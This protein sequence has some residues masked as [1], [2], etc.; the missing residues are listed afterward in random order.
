MTLVSPSRATGE[1]FGTTGASM[2]FGWITD[3]HHDPLK[4]TDPNQGGKYFQ[5][6]AKKIADIT[7]IFNA[8]T[9]LSFVFQNGDFIDGSADANTALTDLATI[10]N[11]LAVNVPKYHNLGNHEM[12]R[13]TK[14]QVM[15]VTGQPSKWYSF[16]SGG[17]TF[18][19]LDGN[20]LAD[21]DAADLSVSSSQAGVSPYVSYI[22]PTQ[23]AWLA[24]TISAS[25]YP[26]VILCH[27]PIYYALDGFSWGL[28]N[29]AAVRAILEPFG[30]KIIACVCG[31]RHDNY[32]KRL[33]GILYCTTHATTVSPYPLLT[34]SII[35]VYPDR[36]QIKIRG[37]GRQASHV[38]A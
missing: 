6:A 11:T 36:R 37:Y 22:P 15:A 35:T 38:E 33:N 29:S 17:I 14:A 8:R 18:I 23:R 13:L 28:S 5:D 4:A 12:T 27:Y 31:H 19:A 21:D 10:N 32:F 2:S 1:M 16:V 25:P 20:F 7:A 34:Y 24:S 26:C 30:N 9:D 3:T